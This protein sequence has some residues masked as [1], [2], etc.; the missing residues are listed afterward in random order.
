M[1]LRA[2]F[3]SVEQ[4]EGSDHD[5]H[6]AY[7]HVYFLFTPSLI[8]QIGLVHGFPLATGFSAPE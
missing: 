3:C 1:M 6:D 4:Y 5:K 2:P 8:R 7:Q